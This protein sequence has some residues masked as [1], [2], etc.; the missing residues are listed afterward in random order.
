MKILVLLI[1]CFSEVYAQKLSFNSGL[2]KLLE[3][4]KPIQIKSIE[5]EIAA[6]KFSKAY[7]PFLPKLNFSTVNGLKSTIPSSEDLRYEKPYTSTLNL[8]LS[9]NLYNNGNDLLEFDKKEYEKKLAIKEWENLKNEEILKYVIQYLKYSYQTELVKIHKSQQILLTKQYNQIK[10]KY[11]RGIK[12]Y[13]DFLRVKTDLM[14]ETV[15][16]QELDR[17]LEE[18][19]KDLKLLVGVDNE[20]F[21]PLEIKKSLI[22]K[23]PNLKIDKGDL[24][25]EIINL[26][27]NINNY[28]VKLSENKIGPELTLNSGVD[29]NINNYIKK[30]ASL[31]QLDKTEWNVLLTLKINLWDNFESANE[32]KIIYAERNKFIKE[33]EQN[34][35]EYEMKIERNLS[36]ME[37]AKTNFELNEKL[38]TLE[39]E[40]FNSVE[41]EFYNGKMSYLDYTSALKDLQKTK[42][43]Y[44]QTYY[45]LLESMSNYYFYKDKIY[46]FV[47]DI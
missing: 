7:S 42:S 31:N 15:T 17:T 12:P 8:S 6:L 46:E 19:K 28:Q 38:L 44:T 25:K 11:E 37:Q 3:E 1:I 26:K 36:K 14:R 33:Q 23:Y 35:N 32:K 29:Y 21:V 20:D 47:K 24:R 9:T 40:N 10:D 43:S 45:D 16:G 2:N 41:K 18:I 27:N 5:K 39:I 13:K 34:N 22:L 4:S 30:S